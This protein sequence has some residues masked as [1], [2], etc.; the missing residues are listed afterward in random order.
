M[1][2]GI[3]SDGSQRPVS[4]DD[5]A[6]LTVGPGGEMQ[7][8]GDEGD[9]SQPS[10]PDI[11][12][13]DDQGSPAT[14]SPPTDIITGSPLV[15]PSSVPELWSESIFPFVL[16]EVDFSPTETPTIAAPSSATPT[17]FDVTITLPL[18][19]S[20]IPSDT[21]QS[22]IVVESS[23][24]SIFSPSSTLVATSF[25]I[26]SSSSLSAMSASSASTSNSP[27]VS[28]SASNS[29]ASVSGS[30][31]SL[32][33]T[34]SSLSFSSSV[35]SS[36]SS[37]P[38]SSAMSQ[39][40]PSETIIAPPMPA[41]LNVHPPTFYVG[42][43]LGTIVAV[44]LLV[45]VIAWWLRRKTRRR[46]RAQTTVPWGRS[47]DY[48][49]GTL[50]TGN[51]ISEME[52]VALAAHN[53]GSRQDLAHIQAWSSL[54][55]RDVGEPK[56]AQTYSSGPLHGSYP[57]PRSRNPLYAD[58]TTGYGYPYGE[59]EHQP[60]T[61][62]LPSHLVAEN[63]SP[64][65]RQRDRSLYA[66]ARQYDYPKRSLTGVST[67]I[68]LA[69]GDGRIPSPW[70]QEQSSQFLPPPRTMADRL[71]NLGKPPATESK[72]DPERLPS[73]T[74]PALGNEELE[75]WS[76]S[77]KASLVN[78]FN[79]VAANLG[80]GAPRLKEEDGLTAAPKRS[81]RRARSSYSQEKADTGLSRRESVL[82]TV[83]KPWTL[84]EV[85]DG[86]GVVHLH[87]PELDKEFS[88]RRPSMRGSVL[89][90]GDGENVSTFND[91][92]AE[93]RG[94]KAGGPQIA[95]FASSKPKRAFIRPETYFARQKSTETVNKNTMSRA[96][97]LYSTQSARS[98]AQPRQGLSKP[99]R[100][101]SVPESPRPKESR[102]HEDM[103][104]VV[105]APHAISRLSSSDSSV[106]LS[107]DGSLLGSRCSA[108]MAAA[109]AL[110][111]R[112][113]R[114]G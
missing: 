83:S 97:S 22:S 35:A 19:F 32:S 70:S 7:I 5:S 52:A 68:G 57:Y 4:S 14:D 6:G 64:R 86:A 49:D 50:E 80:G 91:T 84:E 113:H 36:A 103:D 111:E 88:V 43:G 18:D 30:T 44:A 99:A 58:Q 41:N 63:I 23:T 24:M 69:Y 71:R 2:A 60:T 73:P 94:F 11:T 21:V 17:S 85:S 107:T 98:I 66:R 106:M 65:T 95:L 112:R 20:P 26:S 9:L 92:K 102:H 3:P 28:N 67:G 77:L 89:S 27:S 75:Q 31:S 1:D 87:L 42:I 82:T 100:I 81:V 34:A 72:E 40:M 56:R 62:H 47:D 74:G 8:G 78:A 55:D 96:S 54:G 61:R 79:A 16:S 46:R 38:T 25:T 15:V 53:L 13:D 110:K 109:R 59:Y 108:D 104:S 39:H 37:M 48:D 10:D 51:R 101:P 76:S 93:S 114:V 90:F 29:G 45:A 105:I 12:P 33:F